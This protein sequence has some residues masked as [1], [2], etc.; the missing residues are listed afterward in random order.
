MQL[1]G[2]RGRIVTSEATECRDD[3]LT[4]VFVTCI[5]VAIDMGGRFAQ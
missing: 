3:A 1:V 2:V 5:R 4:A